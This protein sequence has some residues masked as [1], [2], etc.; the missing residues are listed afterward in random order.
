VLIRNQRRRWGSCGGDG[1]LRFNWR[2]VHAARPLL[3]CVV[4]HELAHLAVRNH[5]SD[6]WAQVAQIMPDHLERRAALRAIGRRL[7]L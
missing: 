6:F 2:L 3:D 4:V 7:M 5:S 1:T